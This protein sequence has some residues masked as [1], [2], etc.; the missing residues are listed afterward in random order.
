MLYDTQLGAHSGPQKAKLRGFSDAR[1][2]RRSRQGPKLDPSPHFSSSHPPS[3]SYDCI[4]SQSLDM[5]KITERLKALPAEANYFSLEF[6]PPKTTEVSS[7]RR[8]ATQAGPEDGIKHCHLPLMCSDVAIP[9]PQGFQNILPRLTRLAS[10]RPLFITVTW[11]AGGSTAA[12][13]L[14]L[15]EIAQRQMGLTTCLHLTCTNMRK[16]M[17]DRTL[18]RCKEVGVRNILALRGDEPRESEYEG[19]DAGIGQPGFE[20]DGEDEDGD[21]NKNF[22][23]EY[24]IDL[25]RYIRRKHGDWFCIGVAAYPEGHTTSPYSPTQSLQHDLPYLVEK[26]QAGADFIMT[27]LFYD[28][29]AFLALEKALGEHESGVFSEIPIIPGLMPVQSWGILTRVTKLTCAKV[30]KEILDALEPVKGDDAAIKELGVIFLKDIIS[31]IRTEHETLHTDNEDR[32]NDAIRRK[33]QPTGFHFYTLNL[34]K[35]VAQLLEECNLLPSQ[36]NR[37]AN[38]HSDSAIDDTP[39]NDRSNQQS[40]PLTN[41]LPTKDGRRLSS[42]NA[43]PHNRVVVSKPS[44]PVTNGE[45]ASSKQTSFEAPEDEAGVP[46]E[47]EDSRSTALAISE[48]QGSRGREATW[49]DYPNGRFG[50]ARSPG[51]V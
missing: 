18:K 37:L 31:R 19:M 36:E 8:L 30:P 3:N 12:K 34:E 51:T 2:R 9:T 11:G 15:A 14:D 22:K 42:N 17:L 41:T 25:V 50:D 24:A 20:E 47:K 27:Q 46:R 48:G 6:F 29:N 10:L 40:L 5:D 33:R 44:A 4:F 7:P 35:A 13:S 1:Q 39:H 26:T 23:F 49:D 21:G 38:G 45:A 43:A 16:R 32:I 28:V